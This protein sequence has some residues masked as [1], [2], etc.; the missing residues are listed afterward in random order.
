L[1]GTPAALLL[2]HGLFDRV[3]VAD[4]PAYLTALSE[5]ARSRDERSVESPRAA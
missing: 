3:H 4:R 1:F 5:A 2:E